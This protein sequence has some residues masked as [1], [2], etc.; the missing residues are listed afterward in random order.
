[1]HISLHH[2]RVTAGVEPF[3]WAFLYQ[4]M[5]RA[6][7]FLI[8]PIQEL[9]GEQAQVVLERLQVVTA[10]IVP[11][12]VPEHLADGG[13]LVG[14]LVNA[15]VVGIQPQ[16]QHTQHQD[17]PLLHPGSPLVGI[18]LAR[19]PFAHPLGEHLRENGEHPLAQLTG[20]VEVL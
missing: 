7:H 15:V 13:V 5:A 6:N 2:E 18:G 11:A 4:P 10:L 16:A 1:V 8:D 19:D 12:A 20:G 17:L 3:L 14:Q 9:G